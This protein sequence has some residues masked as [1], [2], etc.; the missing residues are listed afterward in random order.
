MKCVLASYGTRGDV[1]PC[2][3]VGRELLRRGHDVYIAVPP[4]L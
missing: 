3:A 2:V 1:E 4:D